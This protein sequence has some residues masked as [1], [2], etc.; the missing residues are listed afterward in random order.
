MVIRLESS[1]VRAFGDGVRYEQSWIVLF[2]ELAP[3]FVRLG[4]EHNEL[5]QFSEGWR[6]CGQNRVGT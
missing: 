2:G 6:N 3:R 5:D 1:V 4:C